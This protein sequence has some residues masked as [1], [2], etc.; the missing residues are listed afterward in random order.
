M[1]ETEK[2]L[3]ERGMIGR[4]ASQHWGKLPTMKGSREVPTG[5]MMKCQGHFMM[6]VLLDSQLKMLEGPECRRVATASIEWL[7][8][9]RGF[10][11]IQ[12]V[13]VACGLEVLISLSSTFISKACQVIHPAL[14]RILEVIAHTPNMDPFI[15][16][17]VNIWDTSVS[18]DP[19]VSLFPVLRRLT[20]DANTT[21]SAAEFLRILTIFE[22]KASGGILLMLLRALQPTKKMV[23]P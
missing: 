20:W 6:V 3:D 17:I 18:Y 21:R 11:R 1:S 10:S 2:T 4:K 5:R 23:S 15:T 12:K 13:T 22:Y 16:C 9:V 8:G 19:P 7:I 14:V